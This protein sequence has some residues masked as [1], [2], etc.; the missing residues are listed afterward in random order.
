MPKISQTQ[1][2]NQKLSPQQILQA[3]LFQLNSFALEQRLYEEMERNPLLELSDPI[4]NINEEQESES[5]DSDDFELEELYSNTDDFELGDNRQRVGDFIENI[6]SEKNDMVDNLKEQLKDLNLKTLD[7]KIAMEI[8]DNLDSKGYLS[9]EPILVADRFSVDEDYIISIK[10]K[11]NLLNPPGVASLNIKECLASQLIFHN[12]QDSYAFRII[13]NFFED[14]STANYDH[15]A[16]ELEISKQDIK[17]AL[18]VISNLYLY[19]GDGSVGLSKSTIVP[20]LIMEKRNDEWVIS[21]NDGTT[22]ELI[23]NSKYSDLLNDKKTVSKTQS[24]IKKNYNSAIMFLEAIKQRKKTMV[25]VMQ[26]IVDSQKSFFN[27]DNKILNPMILKDIASYLDIDISTVS[28]I[29]NGK[30]VQLPWGIFEMRSF[31]SE[32]VK[33]KNGEVISNT[34]LKED[35]LTII[36][37]E[38]Y[39]NP[40]RDQ[41]IVKLLDEKGYKIARRTVSKYR[42]KLNIPNF[43]VRKRIKALQN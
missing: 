42:E 29:C 15:I 26:V 13:N 7:F 12:Y 35:I 10:N 34:V 33:M 41:D 43:A 20:D 27:S 2:L 8:I 23:L 22:P 30:Y 16:S 18:D 21:V 1:E 17:D 19:P 36:N 32:G 4:E 39:K 38:S 9:I 28:R 31:F 11:I 40:L 5:Q 3:K 6:D 14:F 37:S 25:A 24:F